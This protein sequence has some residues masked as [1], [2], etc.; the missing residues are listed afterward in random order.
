M[1]RIKKS[2]FAAVVS[3]SIVSFALSVNGEE[4]VEGKGDKQSNKGEVSFFCN[5]MPWACVQVSLSG[6]G[7]KE[8][9]K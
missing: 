8:P 4:A 7:G 6:G 1:K 5:L 3:I 2:V 9:P